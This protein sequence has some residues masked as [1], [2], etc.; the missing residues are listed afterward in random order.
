M[1]HVKLQSNLT[2]I[3]NAIPSARQEALTQTAADIVAL[4][5]QL[6]PVKTGTLKQSY[7]AVPVS[8][9]EVHI[10]SREPH[11]PHVEFG[12]RHSAAQPHLTP[13]FAQS[14]STFQARL[15]EAVAR[16]TK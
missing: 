11:A 16:R 4:T 10:G 2:K 6:T 3:A 5:K 9:S 8:S 1:R 13:A 7:G 15:S 12:T 14:A